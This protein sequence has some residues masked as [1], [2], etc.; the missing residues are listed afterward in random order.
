V[1]GFLAILSAELLGPGRAL[2]RLAR[3]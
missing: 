3:P 2:P 1:L